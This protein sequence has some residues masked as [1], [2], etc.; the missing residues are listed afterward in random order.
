MSKR[1]Q[2][3]DLSSEIISIMQKYAGEK[4]EELKEDIDIVA[5]E[6]VKK[7]KE[8]APVRSSTRERSYK[9]SGKSYPPGTY[10]KSWTSKTTDENSVRKTRTI[11]S[12]GQAQLAHLLEKS[13]KIVFNGRTYG[14]TAAQPHIAPVE[15]WAVKKL[16]ERTI[17]RIKNEL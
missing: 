17:T 8:N 10:K 2:I 15:E 13:H 4:T 9:S 11:Y 5:K 6:A 3:D 1:V 16:Q 12:K 7:I 14:K